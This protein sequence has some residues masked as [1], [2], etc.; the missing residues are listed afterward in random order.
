MKQQC[1]DSIYNF[2]HNASGPTSSFFL[3]TSGDTDTKTYIISRLSVPYSQPSIHL[4]TV[5]KFEQFTG[6]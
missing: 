4:T 2:L 1:L 3:P 6:Q 5:Y